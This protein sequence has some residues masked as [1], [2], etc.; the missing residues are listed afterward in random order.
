MSMLRREKL[1]KRIVN[2]Q[3]RYDRLADDSLDKNSKHHLTLLF[4]N[5]IR[6]TLESFALLFI[7][8][9]LASLLGSGHKEVTV[10]TANADGNGTTFR[11]QETVVNTQVPGRRK[12]FKSR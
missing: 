7:A 3:D 8:A 6:C 1:C 11:I 9:L 5:H 10:V 4:T 12:T 2:E